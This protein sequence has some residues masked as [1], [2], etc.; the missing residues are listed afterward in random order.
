VTNKKL[1][2]G[3]A[4]AIVL[5]GLFYLYGGH[6]TPAGQPPLAELNAA[7]LTGLEHEF[8]NSPA[9]VRV[10]LLLSPT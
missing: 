1:M 7:T 9:H 4:A 10:L 3:L 5:A 8:N 2:P 6:E